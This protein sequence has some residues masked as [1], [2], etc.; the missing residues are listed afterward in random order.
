VDR[1]NLHLYP[2]NF[3]HESRILKET[4]SLVDKGV[5]DKIFIVA[6]LENG[7]EEHENLDDKREVWRVPLKTAWMSERTLPK[8][9]KHF[10]WMLKIFY[11]FRKQTIKCVNCHNLS[12]LPIGILFKTFCK[13]KVVYDTH[14]METERC[15]WGKIRRAL[16]KILEKLLIPYVD[17]V[18]VVSDSIAKWYRGHYPSADVQVIY[19]FPYMEIESYNNGSN[20]LKEKF[21]M[22]DDQILF[23]YQGTLG[24][25]RGIEILLDAFSKVDSKKH[26][27]F[28]GYGALEGTIKSYENNFSNIHFQPAVSPEE[29]KSYTEGADVGIS[30]IENTCLSYFYSLPNKV[31]EYILSGL[32]VLV[33]DFPD[34][35]R[36]VDEN[37]CGWKALPEERS[38]IDLIE[39]ISKED[40]REKKKNVLNCRNEFTWQKEEGKLLK[41]YHNLNG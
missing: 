22:Q 13:S 16:S 31:F 38:V 3:K 17:V 20:I 6:L 12:S 23:I 26:I 18:L 1:I 32:P 35:A 28:M 11:R 30:L 39:S 15:G 7:V 40:I 29:V 21:N 9:I 24:E 25:S 41:T 34:M 19:N 36:V 14:E 8:I 4:R 33:S 37:K 27:V 2:S 10:E 5:F